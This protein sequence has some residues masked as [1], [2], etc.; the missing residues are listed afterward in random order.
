MRTSDVDILIIPGW[1][2]SGPEH[3]QTR[4]EGKLSTAR[5]II[6]PDW[7]KP[8]RQIWAANIVAAVQA[9][10]RPVVLVAH[11][12]G[13]SSVGHAAAGLGHGKVAGAFLVAPASEKALHAIPAVPAD[14]ARHSRAKLPFRAVLA[15]STSDPYCTVDE[16]QE[17]AGAWGA[18]FS[19][20]G[21][22]GHINVASGHGPWPEGLMR[23]AG[24][25]RSLG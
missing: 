21:D 19:D 17:L 10:S 5:R 8:D 1:G 2:G 6:Q 16:A 14:F 22:A 13:N 11:S 3:W 9:A 25:L 15:A 7:N 20:A 23:F 12:A 24:F 18:E 4:W